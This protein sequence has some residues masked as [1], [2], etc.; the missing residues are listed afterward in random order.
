MCF[1]VFFG[2]GGDSFFSR[3]GC[4]LFCLF[5]GATGEAPTE[6]SATGP[7]DGHVRCNYTKSTCTSLS[8]NREDVRVCVCVYFYVSY[9][10]GLRAPL[11]LSVSLGKC[12]CVIM[13][14]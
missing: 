13:C 2:G 8:A 6:R 14:L 10:F 4:L 3:D 12:S 7:H 9:F 5:W 1:F 11:C